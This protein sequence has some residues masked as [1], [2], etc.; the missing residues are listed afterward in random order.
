MVVEE[1]GRKM[2]MALTLESRGMW[3]VADGIFWC[4]RRSVRMLVEYLE[5]GVIE[6]ED[7]CVGSEIQ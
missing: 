1:S 4:I 2:Q 5:E 3:C 7:C 6:E